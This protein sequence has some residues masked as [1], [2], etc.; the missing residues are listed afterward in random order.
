MRLA[1]ITGAQ[2]VLG[3]FFTEFFS[4][5]GFSC[6]GLSRTQKRPLFD[7][8]RLVTIGNFADRSTHDDVC[9]LLLKAFEELDDEP[10]EVWLINNAAIQGRVGASTDLDVDAFDQCMNANFHLPARLQ[11]LVLSHFSKTVRGS[12]L[13]V[14]GGG[15]NDTFAFFSP[16]AISKISLARLSEQIAVEWKAQDVSN[17]RIACCTPGFMSSGFHSEAIQGKEDLPSIGALKTKIDSEDLG[18]VP[19]K[20]F[21]ETMSAYCDSDVDIAGGVFHLKNDA[22]ELRGHL[23]KSQPELFKL[24]RIDNFSVFA[25]RS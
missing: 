16:Y 18:N 11:T 15:V 24:R 22:A 1:I 13:N 2:G 10:T 7:N 23:E 20:K 17:W 21:S 3:T 8:E 14:V 12:I 25:G 9:K 4:A 6:F 19:F 5:V